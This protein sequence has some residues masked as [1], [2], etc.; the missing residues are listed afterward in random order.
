MALVSDVPTPLVPAGGVHPA[1]PLPPPGHGLSAMNPQHSFLPGEP[2]LGYFSADDHTVATPSQTV[3]D[4]LS[5]EDVS[6]APSY[7]ISSRHYLAAGSRLSVDGVPVISSEKRL[8]GVMVNQ[9]TQKCL[10][11][12]MKVLGPDHFDPSDADASST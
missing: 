5:V 2:G 3:S 7:G 6:V 4:H 8:I 9:V 11:Y 12:M 10:L 1:P